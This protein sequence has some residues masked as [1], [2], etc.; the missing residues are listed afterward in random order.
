MVHNWD[1]LVMYLLSL[2]LS[3]SFFQFF[4]R[5]Y[6]LKIISKDMSQIKL[7]RGQLFNHLHSA[8]FPLQVSFIKD[9]HFNS[10]PRGLIEKYL[11]LFKG[12]SWKVMIWAKG[13]ESQPE[14]IDE[15][16]FFCEFWLLQPLAVY[17]LMKY[18]FKY[19]WSLMECYLNSTW[20]HCIQFY[21][22]IRWPF[23]FESVVSS[24][25]C[26]EKPFEFNWLP[27]TVVLF[28]IFVPLS[29]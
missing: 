26:Y 21:S 4:F 15:S 1:F 24:K 19:L 16:F 12:A 25:I 17:K 7:I 28:L 20:F 5:L 29:G 22:K 2:S 13:I 9:F 3:L 8:I 10:W 23:P 18:C 14:L 6:T 27:M 11:V